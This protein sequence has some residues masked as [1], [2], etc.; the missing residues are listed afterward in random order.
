MNAIQPQF[1]TGT[2]AELTLAG[3]AGYEIQNDRVI[4]TI[5]EIANNRDFGDISGTLSVELWALEQPYNGADF[6]GI[7]LAGTPI[8]ELFG[9][10]FLADS[11]YE[12]DFTEPSDGTWYLT[13][14]LREWT[15]AGYVTRDYINFDVPYI[16]GNKP[17]IVRSEKDNVI[18]VSFTDNKKSPAVAKAANPVA[19][20]AK[21]VPVEPQAIETVSLNNAELKDIA[22]IKGVSTKLAENIVAAR[23]FES[24]NAVLKVKGMGAKLLEKIRNFISL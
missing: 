12:L 6:Y 11:R 21:S 17:T 24:F 16:V 13:L 15:E 8:G 19:K 20:K 9:Q 3:N 18:S 14:M 4:I 1:N 2:L 22:A 7:A 10:H 23:P 5:D